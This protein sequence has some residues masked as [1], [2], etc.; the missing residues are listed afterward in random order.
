MPHVVPIAL[1][2]RRASGPITV[3]LVDDDDQVRG[4]CRSLLTENGLTVLEAHDGLEALLTSIQHRGAIDLLITDVA[5]PGIS[6]IELGRVF[7]DL[8]A[9]VNVL[10]ISPSPRDTLDD[11]LPADC[12][13]LAKPFAPGS[14]IDAVRDAFVR[15]H[16][17]GQKLSDFAASNPG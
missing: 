13:L 2:T 9:S 17:T 14:L 16:G 11:R 15:G 3:L 6:G 4:F 10:Y 5:M 1:P 8:W 12:V 7:N